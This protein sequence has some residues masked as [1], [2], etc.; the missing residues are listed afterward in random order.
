MKNMNNN[1][2]AILII[3]LLGLLSCDND[4]IFKTEQY[5]NVFALISGTDN[6]YSKYYDLREEESIGYLSASCGGTNLTTRDIN[7]S[8][9]EDPLL[10]EAYNKTN[11]DVE[12]NKYAH[13][14]SKSKYDIDSYKLRIPAGEIKASLPI[15]IRPEG[16]SPDSIYFIPIRIDSHDSYEANPDK[17]YVLFEV[18]IKNYYANAE[19]TTYNLKGNEDNRNIFGTKIMHPLSANKVRIMAGTEA[20][21]SNIEMHKKYALILN[22]NEENKVHITPYGDIQVNQIDDDFEYPNT[23]N[24]TFDGYRYYKTFLLR[25]NFTINNKTYQMREELRL[26]FDPENEDEQ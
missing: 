5:K 1:I 24:V 20:Y 8:L 22:I 6:I 7:M 18:R 21:T 3:F 2:P 11:Y 4:E 14:L 26:Q 12:Y 23:F 25:Y 13:Q 10:I 15:R 9:V 16:L 17:N 19:G